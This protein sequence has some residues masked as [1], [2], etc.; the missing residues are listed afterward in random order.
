MERHTLNRQSSCTKSI[1]VN[2]KH[3]T[4]L[5]KIMFL[6]EN[7][8]LPKT[9]NPW[10]STINTWK[11]RYRRHNPR[12]KLNRPYCL[13]EQYLTVCLLS[14]FCRSFLKN[15]YNALYCSNRLTLLIFRSH[16][17]I[18]VWFD[19]ETSRIWFISIQAILSNFIHS[20]RGSIS[21]NQ[22]GR[23]YYLL[24]LLQVIIQ[25]WRVFIKNNFQKFLRIL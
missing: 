7:I 13:L 14:L 9:T 24:C 5:H 4:F 20:S 1:A 19:R 12:T 21:H 22:K 18:E 3:L 8:N 10:W 23:K 6:L 17:Y 2:L 11:I 25:I 15:D 16:G